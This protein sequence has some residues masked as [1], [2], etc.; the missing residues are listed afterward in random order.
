M[1]ENKIH[2]VT[3]KSISSLRLKPAVG[4]R[5]LR[6]SNGRTTQ[7]HRLVPRQLVH[8]RQPD[9]EIGRRHIN[10]SDCDARRLALPVRKCEVPAGAAGRRIEAC[11][12]RRAANA[13][14]GGQRAERREAARDEPIGARGARD[15]I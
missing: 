12:G 10:R 8:R 3:S 14:E 4:R 6:R 1:E 11:D 5:D 15:V 2:G 9:V 13:R 7:L